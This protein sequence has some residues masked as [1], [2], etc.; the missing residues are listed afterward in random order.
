MLATCFCTCVHEGI[1][2]SSK[3]QTC[4]SLD[5]S[6]GIPKRRSDIDRL[7]QG[8]LMRAIKKIVWHSFNPEKAWLTCSCLV[9][10]FFCNTMC[11]HSQQSVHSM[12]RAASLTTFGGIL[13]R[14]SRW[15]SAIR[16]R[17]EQRSP[18]AQQLTHLVMP[19]LLTPRH[20]LLLLPASSVVLR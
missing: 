1:S 17:M 4:S 3:V 19:C 20:V 6:S 12:H 9:H 11:K 14:T 16:L 8:R 15:Q 5:V 10:S 18:M 7:G 2:P 13:A